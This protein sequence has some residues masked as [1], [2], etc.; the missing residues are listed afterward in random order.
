MYILVI[1]CGSSSLKADIIDTENGK[2]L[3]ELDAERLPHQPHIEINKKEISYNGISDFESV[4]SF[5]IDQLKQESQSIDIQAIGHRVVH[6]GDKYTQPVLIDEEVE[7]TIE[8]LFSI[9]PLHNPA[10]LTGIRICKKA[11]P[12][13]PQIA[14]FDTAFHQTIPNRAK[15]YAIDKNLAEKH[16]I[17]R[18][19][20]HG[21]SHKYVSQRVAEYFNT[22]IKQLRTISCHLGNG[23]SICAVEFGRSAET[24]MGMTPIEGLVM[25]TRSG[26]LDP[27][28]ILSLIR[29][30]KMSVEEVDD[31]LNK[32]SG[33]NGLSGIGNDMRDILQQA[34][35]G[36]EDCRMALQVYVHRLTKYIGAYSAIMGGVDVLLFTGGI[37]ENASGIRKRVCSKLNFMGIIL[38][39]D[40]NKYD[41]LSENQDVIELQDSSSRVK[42]VAVKTNEELA[43]ALD[44]KKIVEGENK[45]NVIPM[46]PIAISARHVHLTQDTFEKL[47]GKGKEL[48]PYKPLS[49]P[50][51]FAANEMVNLIGP[52]NKIE[53]VRILG[54]FRS[55]DQVEISRTDEFSLG[56]DAPIRESGNV[57]GSPGIIL[58]GP[59]GTVQINEGVIQAW[60]HIHMHPDDAKTFGV[61]DKDIVSVDVNV[62]S[63]PLTFKNVLIR[64]SDKFRLEMHI[65]TDEGNAAEIKSGQEGVLEVSS[66]SCSLHDKK[67]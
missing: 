30:K 25:G 64:V 56:I 53:N 60:R 17:K 67:I 59:N 8:E 40:K 48:T 58:E 3:I 65:D 42:I 2:T 51:Q 5:C 27:G 55:H 16:A 38:D 49:Q 43:I 22:D 14:V 29:D 7:K 13:L 9:A 54:P 15:H 11:Y 28:I 21:T 63:R 61:H 66:I 37:G 6:G 46:I 33:L 62:E 44:T 4:L 31:L 52:R 41:K 32:Q 57:K 24:S 1:N 34:E 23:A 18:Y 35:E 26:D 20:F 36:N 39:D 45:V 12:E 19:G 47:F 50:G 10:N